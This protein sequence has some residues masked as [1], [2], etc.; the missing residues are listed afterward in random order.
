[1]LMKLSDGTTANTS[2]KQFAYILLK[3]QKCPNNINP[4]YADI[5]STYTSNILSSFVHNKK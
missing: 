5:V 2:Y 1:M 3:W 4:G